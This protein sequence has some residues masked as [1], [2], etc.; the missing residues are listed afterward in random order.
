[1]TRLYARTR[2]EAHAYMDQHPCTCGDIEFDRQSAVMADGDVLCSR[3][4]GACRTCGA[5]RELVFEL[6]PAP[7]PIGH[8]VEFGGEDPSRILDPGEWMAISEHYAKLTPSTAD[9]LDI[10]CAALEEVI[11]FIPPDADR[12]P[13]DAFRTERGRAIRDREPGRFRRARLEAVLGAHRRVFAEP[14]PTSEHAHDPVREAPRPEPARTNVVLTGDAAREHLDDSLARAGKERAERLAAAKAEAARR[15][16]EPF[17]LEKLAPLCDTSFGGIRAS[18][19][20][21]HEH[22]E[23][24]YYVNYPDV[25]TLAELATHIHELNRW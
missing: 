22:F 24:M 4:F 19:E 17:D 25:M 15:G 7:R 5:Q 11:K 2:A 18:R 13:D 8:R 16:K 3:Y 10:A 12:V 14:D 9:D 6:P 21:R 23:H 1:V 20:S